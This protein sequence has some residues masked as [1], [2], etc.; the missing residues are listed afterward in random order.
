MTGR[1]NDSFRLKA[2]ATLLLRRFRGFR[3]QAEVAALVAAL[4]AG[5]GVLLAGPAPQEPTPTF[6]QGV[7]AVQLRL[8][9][10]LEAT[11]APNPLGAVGACVSGAACVVALTMLEYPLRLGTAS[12]AC[13]RYR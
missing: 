13:S 11:V 12:T 1:F 10:V 9:C 5:S 6:R 7:E 3:L 8:I 2:E 4:A